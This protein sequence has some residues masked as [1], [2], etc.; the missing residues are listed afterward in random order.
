MKENFSTYDGEEMDISYY[1]LNDSFI[2][3]GGQILLKMSRF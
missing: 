3:L 2:T 1:D